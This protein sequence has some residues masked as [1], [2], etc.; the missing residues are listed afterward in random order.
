MSIGGTVA[1]IRAITFVCQLLIWVYDIC[2]S[3][4]RIL[5]V[6]LRSFEVR[7]PIY[8]QK[9]YFLALKLSLRHSPFYF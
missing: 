7:L 1:K 4:F 2:N 3:I 8:G 9:N 5:V 6:F